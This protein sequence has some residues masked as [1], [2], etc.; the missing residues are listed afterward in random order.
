MIPLTLGK[1][2]SA[3]SISNF[4]VNM[5]AEAL[6]TDAV[7]TKGIFDSLTTTPKRVLDK[8]LRTTYGIL[9]DNR[10]STI[11]T[12]NSLEQRGAKFIVGLDPNQTLGSQVASE[13]ER[14]Q[15][16]LEGVKGV[17]GLELPTLEFNK[18]T[19]V[20]KIPGLK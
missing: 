17:T 5:L 13:R 14:L 20:Y 11:N 9:E 19:N 8:K 18:D 15:P 6:F 1:D 4:D 16:Y 2:Q 7:R 10:L 12:L 3:N